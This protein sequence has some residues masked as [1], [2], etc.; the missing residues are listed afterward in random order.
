MNLNNTASEWYAR[1]FG[2]NRG[3]PTHF[4]SHLHLM[5][6]VCDHM[7][8]EKL[9]CSKRDSYQDAVLSVIVILI[10]IQSIVT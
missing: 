3:L 5:T 7:Y 6:H 9:F 4:W 8:E 1:R 10:I 2:N